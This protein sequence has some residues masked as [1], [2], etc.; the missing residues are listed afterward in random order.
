MMCIKQSCYVVHGWNYRRYVVNHLKQ[1]AE[2]EEEVSKIIAQEYE[3]TTRKINQ[4]F[5]NYSAWH[6]RSKLLPQIVSEMGIE[7]RNTV[8]MNGNRHK[9]V[10]K[11]GIKYI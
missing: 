9:I 1:T 4:S 3:F 7:E 5:S 11:T 8:A 2:N 10:V 6:Q